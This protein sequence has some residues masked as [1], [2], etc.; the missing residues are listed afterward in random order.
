MRPE[1]LR[2]VA[3]LRAAFG[4]VQTEDDVRLLCDVAS[5]LRAL[6]VVEAGRSNALGVERSLEAAIARF[7]RLRLGRCR[8]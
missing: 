3:E 5:D 1:I 7:D 4:R 8:S 2:A 6:L